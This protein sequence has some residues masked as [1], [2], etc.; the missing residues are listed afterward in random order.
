MNRLSKNYWQ[1]AINSIAGGTGLIS[2]RPE[3]YAPDLWPT[4][5][6]KSKSN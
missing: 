6:K 3:R 2:K 5:Y 1:R 4:Y